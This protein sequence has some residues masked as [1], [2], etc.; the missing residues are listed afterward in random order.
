MLDGI[1]D[2][3]V[4]FLISVYA[5]FF[6][7]VQD[8]FTIATTSPSAW[9][10]GI[11]WNAVVEFNTKAVLPVAWSILGF[12]LL[13]ELA[14]VMKRSDA[15]GMESIYWVAT[16]LLKIGIAKLIMDNMDIII[17]AI[18]EI[19]T[20]IVSKGGALMNANMENINM[21]TAALADGFDKSNIVTLLGYVIIGIILQLAQWI[22]FIL[23]KLVIYLR[24]IEV[25]VFTGLCALPFATLPSQEYSSIGKNYIKRMM[26]LALQVVFIAVVL[27]C[28][29][30]LIGNSTIK[31]SATDPMGG[32]FNALT[33][34]LLMV[35]ALF[36]TGGWSKSL[37]GAN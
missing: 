14:E 25:Y 10:D 4:D 8:I 27:Y 37:T 32:L 20:K 24:F 15:R 23:S 34:S 30:T 28:Y 12:F 18:F 2:G 11:L 19:A 16:I 7:G 29:V 33:Y 5:G 31:V 35:I 3:I 21:D 22:C 6:S 9:N 36:Q 26:A 13:M 17:L 1:K